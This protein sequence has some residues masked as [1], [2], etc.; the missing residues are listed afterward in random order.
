MLNLFV[1]RKRFDASL[2]RCLLNVRNDFP[3]ITPKR[4]MHDFEVAG[5]KEEVEPLILK[6]NAAKMLKLV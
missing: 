5:F 4:W 2:K 6:D 3:L 1:N